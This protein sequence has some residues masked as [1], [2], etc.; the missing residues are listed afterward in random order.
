[1]EITDPGTFR[2]SNEDIA[3]GLLTAGCQWA[4]PEEGGPAQTH[5]TPELL[6]DRKY[7]GDAP[8]DVDKFERIVADLFARKIPGATS[9]FIQRSHYATQFLEAWEKAH[10]EFRQ[11][12]IDKREPITE[13]VHPSTIA[14]VIYAFCRNRKANKDAPFFRPPRLSVSRG[15]T[16]R[17]GDKGQTIKTGRLKSWTFAHSDAQ[18]AE[19]QL[20][21]APPEVRR[22]QTSP[23]SK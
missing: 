7:I 19:L 6:R 15:V 14:R 18:R 20:P 22:L 10:T 8:V 12:E 23:A 16:T 2:T 1:M 13:D 5:Y 17:T 3:I 9:F 21:P 4:K 11:A